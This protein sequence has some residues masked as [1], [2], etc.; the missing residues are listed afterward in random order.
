MIRIFRHDGLE[1]M[2]NVDLIK[3]IQAGVSTV[4]TLTNGEQIKVKNSLTDVLT[5]IRACRKGI[6]DENR[7]FDPDDMRN[8]RSRKR[9]MPRPAPET[10][11][12]FPDPGKKE[13]L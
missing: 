4:I 6:E 3:D 2:L 13:T 11:G 8:D 9:P 1:L 5:K 7:E 10:A 12:D